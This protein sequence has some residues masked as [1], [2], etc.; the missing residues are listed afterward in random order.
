MGEASDTHS[1]MQL[2]DGM[3]N[4]TVMHIPQY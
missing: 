1:H 2:A 3:R 4:K